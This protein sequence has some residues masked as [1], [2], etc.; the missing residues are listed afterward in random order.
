[1][2]EREVFLGTRLHLGVAALDRLRSFIQKA[3]TDRPMESMHSSTKAEH[4]AE[5]R[6]AAVGVL[7]EIEAQLNGEDQN[8]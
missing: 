7:G 3:H 8:G 1:M 6:E 5:E 4:A 2:G